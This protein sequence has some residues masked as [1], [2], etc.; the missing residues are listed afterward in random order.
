MVSYQKGR[1]VL[2]QYAHEGFSGVV[3]IPPPGR[4][5]AD[6]SWLETEGSPLKIME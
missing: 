3:A 5:V 1:G 6:L 2:S 4:R